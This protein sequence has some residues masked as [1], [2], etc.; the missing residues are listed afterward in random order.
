M[1]GKWVAGVVL[2][3]SS[4]YLVAQFIQPPQGVALSAEAR[5]FNRLKN[6]TVPPGGADF[7]VRVTLAE[8]LRPGEDRVRWSVSR[9]AAVE[10]YVMAVRE[11]GVEA[12]NSFSF[13]RRDTHVE[14]GPR[15]DSPPRERVILEVTPPLRGWAK[16]QGMDWSNA[17]LARELTGRRCRFEGWLLF[18]SNHAQESENVRPGA[19]ANWRATAWELHPVTFIKVLAE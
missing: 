18:D 15:P 19:A 6:R 5:A 10:G 14:V 11:G 16:G 13:V 9:A 1:P 8:L 3:A 4:L 7:D 2:V 12:A 17:A